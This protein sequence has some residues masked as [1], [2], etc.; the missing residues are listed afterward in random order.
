MTP[1]ARIQAAIELMDEISA[2][3]ESPIRRALD[4]IIAY[5]FKS[6][7]FIGSKDRGA[8]AEM[9]YFI[10]RNK[11]TLAWWVDYAQADFTPRSFVLVMLAKHRHMSAGD[12]SLLFNGEKFCP[13]PISEKERQ[14]L[15]AWSAP[16]LLHPQMSQAAKLNFPSWMQPLLEETFGDAL[17]AEMLAMSEEAPVDIRTNSLKTTREALQESLAAQGFALTPTP[18]S[19]LGL[20]MQKRAPI[21]TAEAFRAGWFEMQDA[22]S[23][24]V[25][26][27]ADA[28]PGMKVIDFCA[29]AGGKT[30]AL[31]ASM[32]N[33][34]QLLAWDTSDKRLSQMP[35][36]LRRAGVDNVRTHAIEHEQDAFIKRHKA[37]AD[38]VLVDAPCSGSGTWRRNPDLKWRFTSND[39]EEMTQ[40]QARILESASRLV[41]PGGRMI[42]AT[43]SLFQ[44]ENERQV[45]AFL[46]KKS[47]FRVVNLA[48]IWD[49]DS[50]VRASCHTILDKAYLRVTPH[51]DGVDGFFAAVLE[52][53]G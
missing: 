34:G 35:E 20:R 36:R 37:T 23:Q 21:F 25:A 2:A 51:Q 9:V 27:M 18:L 49:K 53:T 50:P 8:I 28:K 24:L 42:Y 29:G 30:L 47:N 13:F 3:W 38:R 52:H 32:Q 11:E 4:A 33:K 7:R 31:A 40:L 19:P 1:G 5:Y 12:I 6:R 48:E 39:L 43:C 15:N 22:A 26:L 41:K 10:A 46:G 14:W 45:A 17:E 44:S 16:G